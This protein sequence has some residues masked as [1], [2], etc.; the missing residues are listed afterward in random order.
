[1]CHI[2]TAL[3]S[4][5]THATIHTLNFLFLFLLKIQATAV[6]QSVSE[7]LGQK[8][9]KTAKT[10]EGRTGIYG[11]LIQRTGTS[12]SRCACKNI[13]FCVQECDKIIKEAG[14]EMHFGG[15]NESFNAVF[16]TNNIG[17]KS[18]S[19]RITK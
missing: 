6:T 5:S 9:V 4:V 7:Q 17:V 16:I 15:E 1:M 8:K 3:P 2:L 10:Q 11:V 12:P 13:L 19:K 14:H 18:M